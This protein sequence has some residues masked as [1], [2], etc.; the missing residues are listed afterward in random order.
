MSNSPWK[1]CLSRHFSHL[2]AFICLFLNLP[3]PS[4][5]C[6]W[7]DLP[8]IMNWAKSKSSLRLSTACASSPCLIGSLD[9]VTVKTSFLETWVYSSLI[10]GLSRSSSKLTSRPHTRLLPNPPRA[11]AGLV[12]L[13]FRHLNDPLCH[14]TVHHVGAETSTDKMQHEPSAKRKE[15][16]IDGRLAPSLAES[17]LKT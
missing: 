3:C 14:R 8:V 11:L 16:G 6:L 10:K 15:E 7:V 12:T 1:L 4:T 2:S 17:S 9:A 5:S 13:F